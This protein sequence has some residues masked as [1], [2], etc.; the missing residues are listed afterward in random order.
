MYYSPGV[1]F[2]ERQDLG[3]GAYFLDSLSA[4]MDSLALY[5]G[6]H[7]VFFGEVHRL[8]AIRIPLAIYHTVHDGVVTVIAVLDCRR[9]QTRLVA[10]VRDRDA[11]RPK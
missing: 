2:Y 8:L 3:L 9:R 5:G 7:F 4:D 10:T 11:V 1:H 6:I